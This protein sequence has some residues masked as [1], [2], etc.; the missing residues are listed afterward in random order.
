MDSSILSWDSPLPPMH[1]SFLRPRRRN[2]Y[3]SYVYTEHLWPFLKLT[4]VGYVGNLTRLILEH[5]DLSAFC[6]YVEASSSQND[7]KSKR[8]RI[9]QN[10]PIKT[11]PI[12][13][14]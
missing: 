11:S 14:W 9:R 7:P 10:V 12:N 1:T 4:L 6:G 13:Y 3:I 2:T 5:N 8:P